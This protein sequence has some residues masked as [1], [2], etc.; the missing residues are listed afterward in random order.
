MNGVELTERLIEDLKKSIN[1]A[2]V[3]T[4]IP[5]DASHLTNEK[6]WI[7]LSCGI[8]LPYRLSELPQFINHFKPILSYKINEPVNLTSFL[9]DIKLHK[10]I[11]ADTIQRIQ[12]NK[13]FVHV[14]VQHSQSLFSVLE[15]MLDEIHA[16]A[17]RIE[18]C[19]QTIVTDKKSS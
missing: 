6:V 7:E 8:T 4:T 2:N 13:D 17:Q 15:S 16:E 19:R 11:V 18:N 5:E 3:A 12:N 1:A 10:T 14:S 9:A